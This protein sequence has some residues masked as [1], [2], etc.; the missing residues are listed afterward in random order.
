VVRHVQEVGGSDVA[1]ALLVAGADGR[2]VQDCTHAA[3]GRLV[4]GHG[5]FGGGEREGPVDPSDT[6]VAYPERDVGVNRIR[7]PGA[8]GETYRLGGHGHSLSERPGRENPTILGV[9]ARW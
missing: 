5:E 8:G 7:D 1:V 4:A 9:R 3:G 2:G 6:H